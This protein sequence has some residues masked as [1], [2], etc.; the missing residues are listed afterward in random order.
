MAIAPADPAASSPHQAPV[1]GPGGEG[2][3]ELVACLE[4]ELGRLLPAEGAPPSARLPT[5][6]SCPRGSCCGPCSWYAAPWRSGGWWS[7]L[8]R[9][10]SGWSVRMPGVWCMTI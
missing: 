9:L 1:P 8:F 6:L 3:L 2:D 5:M 4:R 7:G 10:L